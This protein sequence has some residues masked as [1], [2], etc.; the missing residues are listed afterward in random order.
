MSAE[1]SVLFDAPGPKA[2]RRHR[3]LAVAG[4]LVLLLPLALV[5]RGLAKPDNNQLTPAKWL[6][7]LEP[8][9]W[10]AYLLPGLLGTLQAAAISVVLAMLLGVLLGL[11]RLAQHRAIRMTCGAVVEFVRSVPVLMMMIFAYYAGLYVL[12]ISGSWL[13]LFGVVVGL[14]GYNSCI[15]A[16]LVRSGIHSLPRGQQEAGWAIGLTPG[17]AMRLILL[18]QAITAM[19]PSIVSQL[20]VILKDSALGYA[21]SYFELLRAGQNLATFRGNLI[22][23]LLVLAILYI[24]I[25]YGLSR[26]ASSLEGGLRRTGR[27]VPLPAAAQ[28]VATVGPRG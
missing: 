8:T 7:F 13:P 28:P 23:T 21:I 26:L 19:L 3:V 18:P 2:L 25:N 6:P 20:V 27:Q 5:I 12:K 10:L 24:M 4:A 9:S 22:P 1:P 15:I 16:E 17:Q 14:T 11:G